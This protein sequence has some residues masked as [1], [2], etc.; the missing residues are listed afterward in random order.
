MIEIY[1]VLGTKPEHPKPSRLTYIKR[2]LVNF[3]RDVDL[4]IDY[5]LARY[6]VWRKT[7]VSR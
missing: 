2:K 5:C 7:H 6:I 4:F 1:A 3:V